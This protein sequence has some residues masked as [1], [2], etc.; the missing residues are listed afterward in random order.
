MESQSKICAIVSAPGPDIKPEARHA[1]ILILARRR[2]FVGARRRV[3]ASRPLLGARCTKVFE[4]YA[5][6][7]LEFNQI[8]SSFFFIFPLTMHFH[9]GN[10]LPAW[11]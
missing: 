11:H 6:H 9:Y 7:M 3:S 2:R 10:I 1:A 5:M 8:L 4:H